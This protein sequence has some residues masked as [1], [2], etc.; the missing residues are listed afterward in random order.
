MGYQLRNLA[1]QDVL[2]IDQEN[3]VSFP[4]V[5]QQHFYYQEA[6]KKFDLADPTV[7]LDEEGK[8]IVDPVQS[9]G[10]DVQ[11]YHPKTNFVRGR[12]HWL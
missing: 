1:N 2:T 11:V 6:K 7:F 3:M 8:V 9:L 10:I 5:T 4:D 12:P